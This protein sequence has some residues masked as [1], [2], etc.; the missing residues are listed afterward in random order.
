MG[1]SL[2]GSFGIPRDK[3]ASSPRGSLWAG[4]SLRGVFEVLHL[5]LATSSGKI[6][7]WR[8]ESA[9]SVTADLK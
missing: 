9:A 4:R 6:S 1:V 8:L 5:L 2:P 7:Q 3:Q